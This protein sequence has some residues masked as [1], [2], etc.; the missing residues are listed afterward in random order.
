MLDIGRRELIAL[1]GAAGAWPVAA[2]AQQ[3]A[4]TKQT[5]GKGTS[6]GWMGCLAIR[7][8]ERGFLR[9]IGNPFLN[10][11]A[12]GQDSLNMKGGFIN[13]VRIVEPVPARSKGFKSPRAGCPWFGQCAGT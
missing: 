9:A 4:P 5:I 3:A 7:T 13:L 8:V 10:G 6:I 2:R 11:Q 1:L 12:L